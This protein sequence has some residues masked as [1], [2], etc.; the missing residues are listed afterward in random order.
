L[1]EGF[2][3]VICWHTGM[4]MG[5]Y[6]IAPLRLAYR[7]RQRIPRFETAFAATID[8]FAGEV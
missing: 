4:G 7:N 5:M 1:N 3:D 6:D 2:T 8:R